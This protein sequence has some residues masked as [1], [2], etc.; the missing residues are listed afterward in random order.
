MSLNEN[1]QY[2]IL[3]RVY[4]ANFEEIV[5]KIKKGSVLRHDQVKVGNSGWTEAEKI[6]ELGKVFEETEKRIRVPEGTDFKNILTNFQ[7]SETNQRALPEIEKKD[8]KT[9]A[10][11]SDQKPVYI[12]TIC[13]NLFCKSCP[14]EDAEKQKICL[15]CGGNC[16]LYMGRLWQM[17]TVKPESKYDLETTEERVKPRN[18]EVVYT[19]LTFKDFLN[20]VVHPLRFPLGLLVGG[21]LFSVL[22]LGQFVTL[23]R[24]GW[25]L[26]ATLLITSVM[27]M[28]KF[29]VL[30]KTIENFSQTN[31]R[32]RSYMPHLR[33]FT[34][35]EDFIS[36]F[37]MG[38]TSYLLAFGLFI[39]LGAAAT[40]YGWFSFSKNVQEI[41]TE[42]LQT[43]E[44]INLVIKTDET[45]PKREAEL[46]AMINKMRHNQLESAFGNNQLADNQEFVKV[47][48]SVL[49]LTLW[50]QVPIYFAFIFGVLF[51]PAICLSSGENHFQ[52]MKKRFLAGFRMMR[53]IGFDYIKI[54]FMSFVLLLLSVS[55]IYGLNWLFSKFEM[56]VAGIFAAI[57][58]G[59][60]FI[61]YFWIA[62]SSIL[63]ITLVNQEVVYEQ[64]AAGF[65]N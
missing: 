29:G 25:M 27:L 30:S 55:A 34:I 28:L 10:L 56:P 39:A 51:F 63:G 57:V 54:L 41:E 14:H 36:P 3:E 21:V 26:S 59:S 62:F 43:S 53:T 61:F 32:Q 45:N 1:C 16:V 19:K 52:S 44:H 17:E 15:F 38:I 48:Y 31:F 12:C 50:F 23:F 37:F 58:A 2:K 6:P 47:V 22:V 7:V 24:G 46:N 40:I 13:S 20:S 8:G 49:R 9:C 5:E 65:L 42:M 35:W 64:S 18:Y 11:H 60:F 33:K 4:Y